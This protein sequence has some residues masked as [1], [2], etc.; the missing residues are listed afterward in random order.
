[1]KSPFPYFGG[2]RR[3]ADIVWDRLDDVHHYIEPFCGSAAVLLARP[4]GAPSSGSETVNDRDGLLIN[5]WRTLQKKP[6]ALLDVASAPPSAVD[7]PARNNRVVDRMSGLV[8]RLL[9]DPEWFNV[10]MAGDWW[11]CL[12]TAIGPAPLFNE[13]KHMGVNKPFVGAGGRGLHSSR[14]TPEHVSSLSK[15]IADVRILCHDWSDVL[16]EGL[17]DY[18]GSPVGVFLDPPYAEG[19]F[20]DDIYS[21]DTIGIAEDVAR[22]A[23]EH[24][25]DEG[26]RIVYCG[27]AGTVTFP[28]GWSQHEWSA[29]GGHRHIGEDTES[30]HDERLWFSPGCSCAP[31]QGL[32]S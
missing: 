26:V 2:K 32:F 19:T 30:R 8:D 1:V 31:Q 3:V 20:D 25:D 28:E 15:R 29:H 27:Y 9:N 12:S 10:Q 24:G 13:G 17:L 4:G 5:F 21:G 7:L 18:C 14:I 23:V 16:T 6:E 22:W 11:Y